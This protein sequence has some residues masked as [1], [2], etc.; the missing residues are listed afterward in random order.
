MAEIKNK[1]N[2]LNNIIQLNYD[3][4]KNRKTDINILRQEKMQWKE[5]SK[6][7]TGERL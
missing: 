1:D 7:E 6:L 3:V 2:M 5:Y 4:L